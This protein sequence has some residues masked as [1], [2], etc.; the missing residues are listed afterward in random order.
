MKKYL[1]NS[2]IVFLTSSFIALGYASRGISAPQSVEPYLTCFGHF[3]GFVF[4]L[5]MMA[6]GLI[7]FSL[8][9]NYQDWLD[10]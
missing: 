3:S 2:F 6:I 8:L 10:K 5:G 7:F 1:P 9:N 4:A